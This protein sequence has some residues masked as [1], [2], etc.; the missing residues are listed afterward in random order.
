MIL[1]RVIKHFRDQEWTAIFLDFLIVVVGVFVGLQVQQ[2]NEA[3]VDRRLGAYY[4]SRLTADLQNDL[5][6][7]DRIGRYYAAVLASA[8]R[9]LALLDKPDANAQELVINAY[10]ATEITIDTQT[11]K[12][13][14]QILSSGHMGLL[15]RTFL[16]SNIGDYYSLEL[17][18]DAYNNLNQSAYRRTVRTLIPIR[19]QKA[20]RENCSDVQDEFGYIAGFVETCDLDVAPTLIIA[21]AQRLRSSPEMH[22]TLAYQYSDLMTAKQYTRINANLLKEGLNALGAEP[23]T[24][25]TQAANEIGEPDER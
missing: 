16:Q 15:P 25:E 1:R 5:T 11:D 10:R 20:L 3:R 22:T 13:W 17:A 7:T 14:N 4:V 9:T 8:E 18:Q 24:P 6:R 21:T 2:W 23:E 12:T 19:L